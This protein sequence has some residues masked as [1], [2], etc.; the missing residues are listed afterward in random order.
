MTPNTR[1]RY[2]FF[3]LEQEKTQKKTKTKTKENLREN[4]ENQSI[5]GNDQI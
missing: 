5:L 4:N 1:T 3:L 2:I